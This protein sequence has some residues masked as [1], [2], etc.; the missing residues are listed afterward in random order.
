MKLRTLFL[1]QGETLGGAERFLLD[2]FDSLSESE[3]RRLA[4]AIVGN[5]I[6]G[7]KE[8]LPEGIHVVPFTFPQVRGTFFKKAQ[9]TAKLLSAAKDLK[10]LIKTSG[11]THVWANTPR[12]MFVAWIAKKILRAKFKFIVIIHDFTVPP[13]LM[14]KISKRADII[15]ANSVPSRQFVRKFLTEKQYEKIRIIENGINFENIPEARPAQK[16]EKVVLLGRIDPQKGQMYALEAADLLA[17]RNPE[18]HFFIVGSPFV[19]DER[20]VEYDQKIRQFVQDRELHNVEFISEVKDPFTVMKEADLVLALPTLP[21]TFGRIV[22]EGLSMG[23]LVI[24]FNLT[25]PKQILS[26]FQNFYEK[27]TGERL[28][29]S[30]LVE[31]ESA[32]SLAEK[33]AFFADNPE[34][35][36]KITA[37]TRKYV[38]RQYPLQETRKRML[39]VLLHSF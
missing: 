29:E 16:V 25:G 6:P 12:T 35:V 8:R 13:F 37:Q 32:M 34:A 22:T 23:A 21:E 11:A 38:E 3:L 26:G 4:P 39:N 30:L 9:I 2:F 28:P 36:Q 19:L 33:I 5:P 27:E 14:Q 17:E 31:P 20:T 7:Y 18:L 10:K 24:A 15:I 1:D